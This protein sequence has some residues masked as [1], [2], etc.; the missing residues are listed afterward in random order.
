MCGRY[1]LYGPKSRIIV[2]FS[3]RELPPFTPRYN[4][5]PTADVL[6]ILLGK[7]GERIARTMRWGLVPGWAKDPAIG[8]KLNNARADTLEEKPAFRNAFRRWRCILPANGFYEW[9]AAP[10]P[11]A[12]KQPFYVRPPQ[13]GGLFALAGLMERWNG[14]D[15]PVYTCCV[16]TTDANP[17]LARIHDRMPVLLQPFQFDA[18]LDPQNDDIAGLRAML[19]PA[20]PQATAMHAVD[21]AVNQARNEGEQLIEPLPPEQDPLGAEGES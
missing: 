10:H 5:A 3:V 16:I 11:K 4:I 2:G 15:G 1:V 21:F 20:P 9:G 17:V 12:R 18:W 7:S 13:A 19:A 8:A 6:T 14:P